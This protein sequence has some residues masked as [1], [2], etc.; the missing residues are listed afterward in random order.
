M[1]DANTE[2]YSKPI[3][4]NHQNLDVVPSKANQ[5]KKHFCMFCNTLQTKFARH[6]QLK[7]K[8]ENLVRTFTNLPKKDSRRLK[9]ITNIRKQGDYLY[10]SQQEFNKGDLIVVR[11]PQNVK[12]RNA[13]HFRPC[14]NCGGMYSALSL[15]VHFRLCK[16]QNDA[17][18]RKDVLTTSRLKSFVHQKANFIM[19]NMILPKMR[20]DAINNIVRCQDVIILFGNRLTQ[21]YRS[22]HFYKMIRSK[23]RTVGRFFLFF[24]K[25]RP[26]IKDLES[27]FDPEMY[28]DVI[29]TIHEMAGLELQSGKYRAP[30]TASSICSFLKKISLYLISE[31]IK[32]KR[33]EM[34]DNIRSFLQLL[35][36]GLPHEVYKTVLENQLENRR[37][38]VIQL[39]S[40]EDIGLLH[41]YLEKKI[42]VYS[43]KIQQ[44]FSFIAWKELSSLLL[45][46]LQLFN[47]R[48]A[49]EIE[50]IN[51]KD[52]LGYSGCESHSSSSN[53]YVR[54][55]IRGKRGRGVPVMMNNSILKHLKL[56]LNLRNEANV[57]TRN[58]Y[59]FGLPGPEFTEHLQADRLMNKYAIAC[60]AKYPKTLRGTELRKHF[61]TLCGNM[62]LGDVQ[63]HDIA[64]Y[65]GHHEKIHLDHY[66]QP[67]ATRDILRIS[68]FLE[69]AIGESSK[70]VTEYNEEESSDMEQRNNSGI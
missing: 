17:K 51:I 26:D 59:L 60:G 56:I 40:Q 70:Y 22:P 11:R 68:T 67:D 33:T 65:M 8:K 61:A 19:K 30:A 29:N 43:K 41:K 10:N 23:L 37:H 47:R 13:S 28:D 50:R 45:V 66:R 49:G 36:E 42:Q 54:F 64:N 58:P 39:P 44:E 25:Q 16:S 4:I 31:S 27:V 2:K 69:K 48:R 20:D 57:S 32:Q 1:N 18:Y 46:Y 24:C 34:R 62:S 14:G 9:I 5:S 63:I 3:E 21:K 12:S 35:E 53:N 7:H 6:L 55:L 38:K 15:A 52:F